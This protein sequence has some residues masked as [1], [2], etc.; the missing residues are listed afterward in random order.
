[1][2]CAMVCRKEVCGAETC[3]SRPCFS[4]LGRVVSDNKSPIVAPTA[5]ACILNYFFNSRLVGSFTHFMFLL[6]QVNEA[7]LEYS[8]N[9]HSASGRQLSGALAARLD[10]L[11]C[12]SRGDRAA[13]TQ[14]DL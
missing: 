7:A 9:V 8:A 14:Y 13:V 10:A 11:E 6:V 1:M 3:L 2:R 4:S 5:V 12:S